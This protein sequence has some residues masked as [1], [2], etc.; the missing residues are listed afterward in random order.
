MILRSMEKKRK[1]LK[2]F[3][4]FNENEPITSPNVWDT[5]KAVIRGKLIP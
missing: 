5:I 4:Q 3:L 1:K 2:M